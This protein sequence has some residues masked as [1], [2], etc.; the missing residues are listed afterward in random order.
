MTP[1]IE[2]T[3]GTGARVRL[4]GVTGTGVDVELAD[5][6]FPVH[7]VTDE[8]YVI[9]TLTSR[10]MRTCLSTQRVR[11]RQRLS[12]VLPPRALVQA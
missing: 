8:H 4:V 5:V 2:G 7:T 10:G 6:I 11:G 9:D 3:Q 12:E 1:I